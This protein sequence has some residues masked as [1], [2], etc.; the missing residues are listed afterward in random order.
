MGR[1]HRPSEPV[2]RVLLVLA[3]TLPVVSGLV[4]NQAAQT[5]TGSASSTSLRRVP[6]SRLLSAQEDPPPPTAMPPPPPPPKEERDLLVPILV[7]VSFGG[8]GLI[9]LYDI[10]FGN[11]L[12]GLTV[13]CSA[14]PWG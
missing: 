11:G 7:G 14:S 13:D 9:V 3:A 4:V 6:A 2:L 1:W 10:F 8:Y 5:L 12:C